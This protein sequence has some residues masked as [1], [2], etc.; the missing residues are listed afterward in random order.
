MGIADWFSFETA[1]QKK[2]KMDRY[3]KKL[4]PFGEEQ[5]NWEQD[6]LNETF[7][8]NKKTKSYHFELLIL[9]EGIA[10]LSDPDVYDEDDSVHSA[11]RLFLT[12]K[13]IYISTE[14]LNKKGTIMDILRSQSEISPINLT[15]VDFDNILYYIAKGSPVIAMQDGKTA[16]LLTAYTPQ[17]IEIMN[18]KTGKKSQMERKEAEK[19][20]KAAGNV[21]ISA[22]N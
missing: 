19:M 4:Y 15:G 13:G 9:R 20:F 6:R 12:A 8:D 18:V 16:V 11:I 3:Y 2:K 22:L 7:P 14:D 10:N 21:Y 1:K 5:K 17:K